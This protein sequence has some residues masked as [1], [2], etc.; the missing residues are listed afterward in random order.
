MLEL[1]GGCSCICCSPLPSAAS[2]KL[3]R[4]RARRRLLAELRRLIDQLLWD[5]LEEQEE[6]MQFYDEEDLDNDGM[7]GDWDF[8]R[9][10][11]LFEL[12]ELES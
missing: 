6:L 4:R 8:W 11:G 2:N 3:W 9:C 12:P 1:D 10:D 7:W 5:E